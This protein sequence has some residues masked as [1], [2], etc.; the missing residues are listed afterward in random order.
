MRTVDR[1]LTISDIHGENKKFLELLKQA[2][3]EPNNDLLIVCGD[4]VDR[5][6]ENVATIA[7]CM[8]LQKKGAII[9]KG[10]HEQFLEQALQEMITGDIWNHLSSEVVNLWVRYNGGAATYHE[11]KDLSLNMLIEILRFVRDLPF[12][13]KTS[14]YIFTHAGANT[15]KPIEENIENETVW[16]EDSFPYCPGYKNKV[17]VFGHVPT[18]KLYS[19]DKKFKNKDAKIWF[20][21]TYK[22]KIGIDCGSIF[23]GRLAALELPSGREFYV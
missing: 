19:Y 12:F 5:G 9:L 16:M 7:T 2:E 1:I 11:I 4:I 3:Y 21:K 23:G 6:E 8:D 13:F 22:D 20:D 15:R 17:M 10:N 14:K 18:W